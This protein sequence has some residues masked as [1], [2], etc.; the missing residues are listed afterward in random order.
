[1]ARPAQG[2]WKIV[3]TTSPIASASAS[4][5]VNDNQ[6]EEFMRRYE[7]RR[8]NRRVSGFD[9]CRKTISGATNGLHQ[10]IVPEF[11]KRLAQPADVYVDRSFLDVDVSAPHAVEQLLATVHAF[12]MGNKEFQQT[13][14]GRPECDGSLTDHDPMTGTI[15][16]QIT[17]LN[18]L[19]LILAT[20]TTQHCV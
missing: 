20:G 3:P 10:T 2:S 13:I 5:T 7:V 1:M 9:S 15:Q 17:D 12:R 8:P 16:A 11:L 19:G 6:P 4:L 18:D 14:L